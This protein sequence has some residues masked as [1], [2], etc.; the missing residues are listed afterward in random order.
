MNF[1]EKPIQGISSLEGIQS[2]KLLD[3]GVFYCASRTV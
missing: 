1:F 2:H 3:T